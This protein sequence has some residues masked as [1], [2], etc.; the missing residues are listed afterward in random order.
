MAH[1]F[2][3]PFSG[4]Q[5]SIVVAACA[6][7][8]ALGLGPKDVLDAYTDW[9]QDLFKTAQEPISKTKHHQVIICPSCGRGQLSRVSNQDGLVILG[10]RLCRYSRLEDR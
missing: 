4:E 8:Q 3:A 10:C 9:Q 2:F 7:M 6:R 1:D 5:A